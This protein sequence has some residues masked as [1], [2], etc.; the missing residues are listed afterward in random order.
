MRPE[1]TREDFKSLFDGF[2]PSQHAAEV[3][4]RWGN[5]DA[6]R[7]TAKRTK[8]YGKPEWE[9]IRRESEEIYARLSELMQRGAAVTD[10][11]VQS[12]IADH[13]A[14]IDR[15]FYPCSI[16]MHRGLGE[17]YVADPRFL[18]NLDKQGGPGFAQFLRDAICAGP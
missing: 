7:E 11:A 13:R 4:Q 14:H 8:G 17:M 12:A 10:P 5:T 18:A 16:E 3:E 6:Y 2:D 9:A 15:W 1:M